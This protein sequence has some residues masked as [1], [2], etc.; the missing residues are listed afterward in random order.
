MNGYKLENIEWTRVWREQC[1]APNNDRVLLIGD[2]IIDGC[3]IEVSK[4]LAAHGIATT[5]FMTSKDINNPFYIKELDLLCEQEDFCYRAIYLQFGGH[6]HQ[7]REACRRDYYALVA[8][9]TERFPNIPILL[10]PFTPVKKGDA[11]PSKHDTP[12]TPSEDLGAHN[13]ANLLLRQDIL[14]LIQVPPAGSSLHFF[15][16]Y[17]LMLQHLDT[18]A[19]DGVHFK[20][21]GSA[22]LGRAIAE[23]ILQILQKFDKC[24]V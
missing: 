21:E 12:L 20:S 8:H 9:L 10:S 1:T 14:N 3:K 24:K 11:D 23:A 4:A 19:P 6:N 15:D 2:S 22:I 17:A 18:Q 5:S 13:C 7:E 16:A